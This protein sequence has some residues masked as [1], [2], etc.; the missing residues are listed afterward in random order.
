MKLKGNF[1][2]ENRNYSWIPCSNA[3]PDVLNRFI[4]VCNYDKLPIRILC[5]IINENPLDPQDNVS[6]RLP[7]S[8]SR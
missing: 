3:K 1:L 2:E 4:T 5:G 8:I 6:I 7:F